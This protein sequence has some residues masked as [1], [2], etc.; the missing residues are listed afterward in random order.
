MIGPAIVFVLI[1]GFVIAGAMSDGDYHHGVYV[2]RL[3]RQRQS[4][5]RRKLGPGCHLGPGMDCTSCLLNDRCYAQM[6][7]AVKRDIDD[8]LSHLRETINQPQLQPGI[9]VPNDHS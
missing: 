2:P 1:V 9:E 8:A 4:A 5:R 7:K 3:A 6:V